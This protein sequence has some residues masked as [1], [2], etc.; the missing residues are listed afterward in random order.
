MLKWWSTEQIMG[1]Y[2]L[3][4][5]WHFT[6]LLHDMQSAMLVHDAFKTPGQVHYTSSQ[7]EQDLLQ[8]QWQQQEI[9]TITAALA[10]PAAEQSGGAEQ[11]LMPVTPVDS[12][13]V[14]SAAPERRLPAIDEEPEHVPE[15]PD[16]AMVQPEA[17]PQRQRNRRPSAL[18]SWSK[19]MTH[20]MSA[21]VVAPGNET[22]TVVTD[23]EHS[24]PTDTDCDA[25]F[26]EADVPIVS[27]SS[28]ATA[29]QHRIHDRWAG[30]AERAQPPVKSQM[31]PAEI[32]FHLV[33][34]H[35]KHCADNK[36]EWSFDRTD[37]FERYFEVQQSSRDDK[38][39]SAARAQLTIDAL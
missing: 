26:A 13:M 16:A 27:Q 33:D 7:R 38:S 24:A 4:M 1:T 22:S 25:T 39:K 17:L 5:N 3:P 20:Q 9:E 8:D 6:W 35:W 10:T 32:A 19:M 14:Q 30:L 37:P 18:V 34:A 28:A 2:S 23:D 29:A 36:F 31:T 11:S 12:A 21:T 15:L